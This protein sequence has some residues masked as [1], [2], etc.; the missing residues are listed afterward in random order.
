MTGPPLSP[1]GRAKPPRGL[2]L[3]PASFCM[4]GDR[5]S[6]AISLTIHIKVSTDV[7]DSLGRRLSDE[8]GGAPV[9]P[10]SGA[11]VWGLRLLAYCLDPHLREQSLKARDDRAVHDLSQPGPVP[12]DDEWGRA[13]V[14]H[15][16]RQAFGYRPRRDLDVEAPDLCDQ[17][18][19]LGVGARSPVG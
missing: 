3:R 13:G 9:H 12:A 1:R 2:M 15:R 7:L 5:P 8:R 6:S 19:V 4:R 17:V 16:S 18:P 10:T 14:P 11:R